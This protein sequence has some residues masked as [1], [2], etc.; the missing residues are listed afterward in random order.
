M[1]LPVWRIRVFPSTHPSFSELDGIGKRLPVFFYFDFKFHYSLCLACHT[2]HP[3][4]VTF[5]MRF[6]QVIE[7]STNQASRKS[8]VVPVLPATGQA[9]P[10]SFKERAVPSV[11]TL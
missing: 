8:F 3:I 6:C 7:F 9:I 1:A 11:T 10:L 2:P 5:H 4:L